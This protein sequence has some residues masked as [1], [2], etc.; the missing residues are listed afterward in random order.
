MRLLVTAFLFV[1]LAL[2]LI[3][4]CGAQDVYNEINVGTPP[5]GNNLRLPARWM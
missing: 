2:L 3:P 4:G 5:N 1:V